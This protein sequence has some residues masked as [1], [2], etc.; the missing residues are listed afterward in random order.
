MK[1]ALPGGLFA[2][3]TCFMDGLVTTNKK[4]YRNN[5]LPKLLE[6][7]L[8]VQKWNIGKFLAVSGQELNP[9]RYAME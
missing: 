6:N 5:Q 7:L 2:T 9:R 3:G 4:W 8:L 1:T